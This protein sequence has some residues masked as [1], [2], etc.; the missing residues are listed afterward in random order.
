MASLIKDKLTGRYLIQLSPG[1]HASRPKIRLGKVTAKQARSVQNNIEAL[2]LDKLSGTAHSPALQEWLNGIPE[3]LRKRLEDMCLVEARES[4]RSFTVEDWAT[5]YIAS[6]PDVKEPTSR[7]WRDVSRKLGAFF[8]G[9]FIEDINVAHAKRFRTYIVSTIGLSENSARRHIGIARQFFNAAIDEGLITKNPFRKQP[10]AV[11]S[12]PARSFYITPEMSEKVLDA[13]PDAQW[14]LIFGLTRWGGLRCPSEV[15][16][17]SWEDIDFAND[18]FTVHAIKTEHHTDGGIRTVPMF[19]ELKPLFQEAFELAEAGDTYCITRYRGNSNLRTQM[20]RIVKKAGLEPWP[21]IFQNLRST[22]ETE[23]F[24][25]TGGNIKA[26]CSW[27]GNSPEIAMQHYAQVT[28]ADFQEVVKKTLISQAEKAV[29]NPV[30]P[31]AEMPRRESQ[32]VKK[33][34]I[35]SP[36]YCETSAK[37]TG[38]CETT[39]NSLIW[40]HLDSN[41]GPTDYES[42]ALTN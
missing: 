39:Q 26:V 30:H 15:L 42:V 34:G 2:A 29:Q 25:L 14:R 41:Q 33:N 1:E 37:K 19:P 28:E 13:C 38:A 27:I 24:K 36:C 31:R 21:K 3:L 23:L 22:R 4:L 6:R 20:M 32:E 35:V 10:V 8:R 11:R 9:D 17:L 12:N 16:R 40:A 5:K 18:R 7:K